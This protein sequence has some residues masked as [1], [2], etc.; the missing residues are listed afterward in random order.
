M[1]NFHVAYFF[2]RESGEQ[3]FGSSEVSFEEVFDTTVATGKIT[4]DLDFEN[5]VIV[6][7][8][9]LHDD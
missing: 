9:E 7:W 8:I 4:K 1:K 6:N 2:T 3:G 5:I